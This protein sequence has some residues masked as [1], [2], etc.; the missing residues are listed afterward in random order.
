[1]YLI[2]SLL[3]IALLVFLNF[4]YEFIIAFKYLGETHEKINQA[5]YFVLLVALFIWVACLLSYGI[6]L[7]T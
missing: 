2:I 7:L 5:I 6:Y 4:F 1:M 3:I